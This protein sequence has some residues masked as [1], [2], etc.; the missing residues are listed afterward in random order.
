MSNY[1]RESD[2]I[3]IPKGNGYIRIPVN[4]IRQK[5]EKPKRRSIIGLKWI[6][7]RIWDNVQF[8]LMLGS[9]VFVLGYIG[10]T[11]A[12]LFGLF[13]AVVTTAFGFLF[14]SKI[15]IEYILRRKNLKYI[16]PLQGKTLHDMIEILAKKAGLSKRPHLFFDYSNEMNAYTVEDSEKS[17]IVVSNGLIENLNKRELVGVLAHEIAHLK[18]RDVRLMLFTDQI[19]RLT[20]YM[21]FFG[22][23]LLLINLPLILLNQVTLPWFP[24]L[25]LITAPMIS[26]LFHVAMSRNRE[27][28][29]DLDAIA[30]SG[31]ATGLANALRKIN[32]RMKF[33]TRFY[34]PYLKNV[35]EILRTHPNTNARI[36]RLSRI[37]KEQS[38][39]LAWAR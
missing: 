14:N 15:K 28:R 34:A 29:A 36:N 18:N 2:Q 11:I 21:S 20:G 17:A 30:L 37:A 7:Y 25:L 24:I 4:G 19:R 32:Y 23:I 5:E 9:M 27:F 8:A 33:W 31:D 35:P 39:E 22:Q 13:L 12:G 6:S 3:L 10:Y 1:N 16:H 26:M 38:G